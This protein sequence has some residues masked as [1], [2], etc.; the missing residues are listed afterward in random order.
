MARGGKRSNAGRKPG[1]VTVRTRKIAD[2]AVATGI[3]PP[4]I[5]LANA[6]HFYQQAIDAEATLA[7]LT[8]KELGLDQL[9]PAEQFKVMMAEIKKVAGFRSMSQQ[10]AEGAAPYFAAKIGPVPARAGQGEQAAPLVE[11]VKEYERKKTIEQSG[12]KVVSLR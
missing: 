7:Q 6:R 11:R 10:C 9:E 2:Q 8:P 4:E 3:S 1:A 12:G 5:M